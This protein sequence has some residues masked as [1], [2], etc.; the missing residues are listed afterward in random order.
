MHG[1]TRVGASITRSEKMPAGKKAILVGATLM[2]AAG[3]TFV[4]SIASSA[5]EIQN[6]PFDVVSSKTATPIK[7][8]TVT[9]MPTDVI[10]TATPEIDYS[11]V[12][13]FKEATWPEKY[14]KFAEGGWLNAT[15]AERQEFQ[16]FL[17]KS[18]AAF[19]AKEG[20]DTSR[21]EKIN[22]NER[23]LWGM[24]EWY[25]KNPDRI[26]TE[27]LKI[28]VTPTEYENSLLNPIFN[29]NSREEGE[30]SYIVNGP[31]ID[32][33]SYNT[34]LTGRPIAG[35]DNLD[36]PRG[37]IE[38]ASGTF[39]GLGVVGADENQ[40]K[41]GIMDVI[42]MTGKHNLFIFAIPEDDLVLEKGY[43][44]YDFHTGGAFILKQ[45]LDVGQS[46]KEWGRTDDWLLTKAMGKNVRILFG[47]A[48]DIQDHFACPHP[49]LGGEMAFSIH[50]ISPLTV[51]YLPWGEQLGS[52][53]TETPTS[54][55]T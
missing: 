33:D 41:V 37:G 55:I 32:G 45:D 38:S 4:P 52:L 13:V 1:Q 14:K 28:I 18:R 47:Y 21:Y 22:E 50:G 46:W 26:K 5:T 16:A 44:C 8:E 10:L 43:I 23:S 12:N 48:V 49:V 9:D 40:G 30:I 39:L 25:L 2:S 27:N 20:I 35:R 36:L 51:P 42:D 19:M 17:E 29:W 7:I 15:E 6:T 24:I 3:C 11:K 53:V 54:T 34:D 31:F